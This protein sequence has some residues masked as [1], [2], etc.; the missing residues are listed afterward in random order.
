MAEVFT[1]TVELGKGVN[2]ALGAAPEEADG[3][4]PPRVGALGYGYVVKRI[5]GTQGGTNGDTLSVE[6]EADF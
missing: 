2:A 5:S 1:G 3:K 4:K 6:I